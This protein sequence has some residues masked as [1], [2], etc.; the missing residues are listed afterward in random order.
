MSHRKLKLPYL[1]VTVDSI[2]SR[3]SPHAGPVAAV[4]TEWFMKGAQILSIRSL[5]THFSVCLTNPKPPPQLTLLPEIS[6][7][8]SFCC[9]IIKTGH[10]FYKKEKNGGRGTGRRDTGNI[11]PWQTQCPL[12]HT[13]VNCKVQVDQ[14]VSLGGL[15]VCTEH[16]CLQTT[17]MAVCKKK[18]LLSI[19]ACIF[20]T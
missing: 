20:C 11:N 12:P 1:L 19:L 17:Q 14:L 4:C 18:P 2:E 8:E 16:S 3:P 15:S 9:Y 5:S 13:S 7:F 6:P 10:K